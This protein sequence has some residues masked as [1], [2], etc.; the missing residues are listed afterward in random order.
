MCST[1]LQ[2]L[3]ESTGPGSANVKAANGRTRNIIEVNCKNFTALIKCPLACEEMTAA[4]DSLIII[5]NI[6]TTIIANLYLTFAAR[7]IIQTM[8]FWYSGYA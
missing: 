1:D 8:L 2:T 4:L 6:E 7:Y 5:E 3:Q